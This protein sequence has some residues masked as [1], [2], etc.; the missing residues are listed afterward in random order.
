MAI[1]ITEGL[2]LNAEEPI[3]EELMKCRAAGAQIAIDDFGTGYSSLAYLKKF[4]IDYIKLDQ[5]FIRD[6]ATDTHDRALSEAIIVMAHQLGLKVIAEG[7]ETEDQRDLL[8]AAGCDYAQGFL[9]SRAL[10]VREFE[11]FMQRAA[12]ARPA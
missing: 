5:T 11:A 3:I 12:T 2:L 6:V 9:F 8:Y 10:P 7:V 1:E 4:H